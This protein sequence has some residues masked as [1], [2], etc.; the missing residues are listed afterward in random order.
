M[1][2]TNDIYRIFSSE[3][4]EIVH[5]GSESQVDQSKLPS[6]DALVVYKRRAGAFT[7][8]EQVMVRMT[9]LIDESLASLPILTRF[10]KFRRVIRKRFQ[11]KDIEII[12][13]DGA[14]VLDKTDAGNIGTF[15]EFLNA[16]NNP[17]DIGQDIPT[18]FNKFLDLHDVTDD[19]FI[20]GI[21]EKYNG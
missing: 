12:E 17:N 10:E 2:D 15:E 21:E 7:I 1:P 5:F 13:A 9:P 14:A 8:P 4:L 19:D 3:G 11:S 16:L 6:S 18:F 20:A